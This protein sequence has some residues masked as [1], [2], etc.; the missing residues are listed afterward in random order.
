MSGRALQALREMGVGPARRADLRRARCRRVPGRADSQGVGELLALQPRPFLGESVEVAR[1]LG[2]GGDGRGAL[3]G[4]GAPGLHGLSP[5]APRGREG[6]ALRQSS[7]WTK[8]R[9]HATRY[10]PMQDY[11]PHQQTPKEDQPLPMCL[12]RPLCSI[13]PKGR[14]LAYVHIRESGQFSP[15]YCQ[16]LVDERRQRRP[17]G[18]QHQ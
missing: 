12:V 7:P 6:P 10:R 8:G 9:P 4:I 5:R 16:W 15:R 17:I 13:V 18:A 3:P 2:R 11:H 1:P 14:Q